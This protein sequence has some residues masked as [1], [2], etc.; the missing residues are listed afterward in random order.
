MFIVSNLPARAR[1]R[2]QARAFSGHPRRSTAAR[3]LRGARGKLHGRRWT[4]ARTARR[5]ARAIYAIGAWRRT[6]DWLDGAAQSR[7]SHAGQIA[8]RTLPAGEFLGASCLV[9]A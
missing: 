4:T 3:I 7:A 6:F 8:L 1:R 2:L 9:V 5:I